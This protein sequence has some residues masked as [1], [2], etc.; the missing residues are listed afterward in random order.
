MNSNMEVSLDPVG[1]P[2]LPHACSAST[3]TTATALGPCSKKQNTGAGTRRRY[4]FQGPPQELIFVRPSSQ[5]CLKP[6]ERSTT[7]GSPRSG[8]N[9]QKKRNNTDHESQRRLQEEVI[10][11]LRG[12]YNYLTYL[13]A[14]GAISLGTGFFLLASALWFLIY[15]RREIFPGPKVDEN[16]K[17]G[18]FQQR[19][20]SHSQFVSIGRNFHTWRFPPQFLLNT[21]KYKANGLDIPSSVGHCHSLIDEPIV[22][23][24]MPETAN[25]QS[26]DEF[27]SLDPVSLESP[28]MASVANSS[29]MAP[30]SATSVSNSSCSQ[31]LEASDDDCFPG[32]C[33][34]DKNP[35][36]PLLGD[37]LAE[38]LLSH[39]AVIS[40]EEWSRD[41]MVVLCCSD[42][43]EDDIKEVFSQRNMEVAKHNLQYDT[44]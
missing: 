22:Q 32:D 1:P 24:E 39:L 29:S 6:S 40:L 19:V 2:I 3:L 25:G 7:R 34:E 38:K 35:P 44:E 30:N 17:Q 4:S 28:E 37:P 43:K 21:S 41:T 9:K 27:S 18:L 10:P 15:K 20:K 13:L 23:D 8:R 26:K 42:Q 31:N 36:Q 14:L 5:K 33:R 11:K 16:L 12:F